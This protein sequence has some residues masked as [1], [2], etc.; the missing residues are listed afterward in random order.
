MVNTQRTAKACNINCRHH[1]TPFRVFPGRMVLMAG[2]MRRWWSYQGPS[3]FRGL[4]I[5]HVHQRVNTCMHKWESPI[6]ATQ[7]LINSLPRAF[8]RPCSPLMLEPIQ[9]QVST[10]PK[11]GIAPKVLNS[12]YLHKHGFLTGSVR[13]KRFC[14]DI[15][16]EN[17]RACRYICRCFQVKGLQE[18]LLTEHIGAVFTLSAL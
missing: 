10:T 4:V 14:A 2:V 3:L 9:K 7:F 18:N 15:L 5:D 17:R 16:T 11:G 13:N 1:I 12:R 6:T 8:S